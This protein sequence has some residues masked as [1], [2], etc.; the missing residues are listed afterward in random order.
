MKKREPVLADNLA[1]QIIGF[2][3]IGMSLRDISKHIQELYDVE[4]SASILSEITDRVIPQVKECQNRLLDDVYPVVWLDAMHY[5]V[6]DNGRVVSRAVYNILALDKLGRKV[7]IGIYI[8][9][10]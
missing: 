2:Y 7:Q 3:G 4:V 6:R 1:P 10:S 8:F 9:E 5:K